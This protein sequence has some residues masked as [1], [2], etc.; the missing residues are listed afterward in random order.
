MRLVDLIENCHLD[1]HILN[2]TVVNKTICEHYSDRDLVSVIEVFLRGIGK[3]HAVPGNVVA[4]FWGLC[5][6]YREHKS[7]T[8]KQQVYIIQNLIDH[9]DQINLEM[10]STIY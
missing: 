1:R 7:F 9:W 2:K 5:D 10:R 3:H 8:P 4:T 6:W